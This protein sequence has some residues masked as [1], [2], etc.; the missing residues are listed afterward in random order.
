MTTMRKALL[1]LV[2]LAILLFT[3]LSGGLG[4][5]VLLVGVVG[6]FAM[7]YRKPVWGDRIVARRWF[8][9]GAGA[10]LI[11]LSLALIFI[12]PPPLS[13][14]GLSINF[15]DVVVAGNTVGI[16]L[17][18]LPF[19]VRSMKGRKVQ[20][21]FPE[22]P[23]PPR[24]DSFDGVR[25]GLRALRYVVERPGRFVKLA[26]PWLASEVAMSLLL[27]ETAAHMPKG[28]QPCYASLLTVLLLVFT[29][30]QLS[31]TLYA[32]LWH[33]A[34]FISVLPIMS[35]WPTLRVWWSYAWRSWVFFYAVNTAEKQWLTWAHARASSFHLDVGVVGLVQ[36][37]SFGFVAFLLASS[38]ALALPRVAAG[39]SPQLGFASMAARRLGWRFTAGLAVAASP[40]L[41]SLIIP[42]GHGTGALLSPLGVASMFLAYFLGLFGVASGTTYLS[43]A[44]LA[45]EGGQEQRSPEG[46]WLP[47]A[48][49]GTA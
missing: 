27:F 7:I 12:N 30:I 21:A 3:G 6:L 16:M 43:W 37:A 26:G 36:G 33:R 15:V 45:V 31:L 14:A 2:G 9:A 34:V 4:S 5:I 23:K 11:V 18:M 42:A 10:A 13:I 49:L 1:L 44:Y 29:A 28:H 39:Q 20:A 17:I 19:I 40:Y 32:V 38:Y 48:E 47:P 22:Q 24:P 8:I 41:I 25:L 35:R 46:S